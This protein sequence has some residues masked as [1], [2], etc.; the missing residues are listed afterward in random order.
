MNENLYNLV[1]SIQ[2][3]LIFYAQVY[4]P[5]YDQDY[6]Q[7]RLLL[8][9]QDDI[10]DRIPA[11]LMDNRTG[12]QVSDFFKRKGKTT[13]EKISFIWEELSELFIYAE[14]GD[15]KKSIPATKE[16]NAPTTAL[17]HP[18][19]F[20]S[21]SWDSE[22]HKEWV[23]QMATRLRN[24]GVD[25]ILD[26]FHLRPGVNLSFFVE[27][28]LRTSNRIIT[29]LT[30]QYKTKADNRKGG[31]GQEYT[32]INNELIKDIVA[33][34]RIIP[35]LRSGNSDNS[36]PDFLKT[37]I[38]VSFTED[39]SFEKNYEEL[40]REIYKSPKITLP[41]LGAKPSF[42]ETVK[43]I[44]NKEIS[45]QKILPITNN[46]I[47]SI[48]SLAQTLTNQDYENRKK[49][50]L[51]IYEIAPSAPLGEILNLV[52]EKEIEIKVAAAICLKSITENLN[53]E[54]G[55][56]PNIRQFVVSNLGHSS[57]FLRYRVFDYIS[58]SEVLQKDFRN[59]IQKQATKETNEEVSS[60]INSILGIKEIK[61]QTDKQKTKSKLRALL[62]QNDTSSA[63][64]LLV[65]H[66]QYTN[67]SKLENFAIL[68]SSQFA[69]L[70]QETING[71]ISYQDVT[72]QRNRLLNSLLS[73]VSEI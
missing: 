11:L 56:N 36:I 68:L 64:D 20:I 34:D 4:S 32:I 12:L 30:P 8:L 63:L 25:V 29:V 10:R 19:V 22:E 69:Q 49:K 57:S 43:P 47:E 66:S 37:Y 52:N 48:K 53:I 3:V 45:F 33:N 73:L 70:Q 28:S 9:K 26:R 50:A 44:P 6:K 2:D 7:L 1:N 40:L 59:E 42:L 60:K 58:I 14:Q 61:P 54:L 72:I 31:V 55:T 5:V 24:D 17:E 35:V 38:Y 27:N 15:I 16:L 21:Y 67:N 62:A 23:L 51:A 13:E 71:T 39:N 41:E 18:I 65:E 46:Q